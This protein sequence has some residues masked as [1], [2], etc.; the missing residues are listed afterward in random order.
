MPTTI[1]LLT[2]PAHIQGLE[3]QR[4]IKDLVDAHGW[5][6]HVARLMPDSAWRVVC[7]TNVVFAMYHDLAA[8]IQ[9]PHDLGDD[10]G[11]DDD[12]AECDDNEDAWHHHR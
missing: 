5:T 1:G 9:D 10:D 11:P 12:V 6:D 7:V 3:D 8:P 2:S 4:A